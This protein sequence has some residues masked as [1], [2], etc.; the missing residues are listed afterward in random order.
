MSNRELARFRLLGVVIIALVV[1]SVAQMLY[2]NAR[3]MSIVKCQTGYIAQIN[4]TLKARQV[5][6]DADQA[7]IDA[8]VQ[9]LTNATDRAEVLVALGKY[10]TARSALLSEHKAQPF[11]SVVSTCG[12]VQD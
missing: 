10:Q 4:E 2:F 1:L 6:R 11:P 7:V 9:D 5:A 3:T 8:L 12:T